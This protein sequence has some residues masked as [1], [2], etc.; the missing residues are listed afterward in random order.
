MTLAA[1][2]VQI[3]NVAF[4][5]AERGA[6]GLRELFLPLDHL[7]VRGGDPRLML[8]LGSGRNNYG[9]SPRPS[10]EC[11]SFAS[12]TASAISERAY[13]RAEAAC[14][15]LM[16]SAIRV[17]LT[18]AFDTR[19]EQMRE[20]L[21]AHLGLCS[22][23]VDVAFS[24]S[25]TDA[26]LHALFVARSLLGGALTT[27]IVSADQT[28]SGTAFTARGRHFAGTTASARQ[29][30]KNAPITGLSCDSVALPLLD[31]AT[32]AVKA[33][34]NADQVV[35]DAVD[36]VVAEGGVVLL[37]ILDSSQFGWR[38]PSDACLEEIATRWPDRVQVVVDACQ[39]RL[40]RA[41]L[42]TYLGRGYIVL[43]SGSKY[44]GGPAFSGALLL[45]AAA[46]RALKQNREVAPGL[47]DYTSRSDWPRGFVAL[48]NHLESRVNLGQ[49]LRWEAALEEI[50]TYYRIPD[51]FRA[52]ALKELG[53][54]IE[55][56]IML[57][58]SLRPV[59]SGTGGS[60]ADDEEFV[61]ATIFP[62]TVNGPR[63]PL[64]EAECRS[65]CQDLARDIGEV[66][67]HSDADR[68]IAARHCL[69]GE[70]AR[71]ERNVEHPAAVLR[72]CVG[73]RQV[74]EAWSPDATMARQSLERQ[75]DRI[76]VVVAKIELSLAHMRFA[77]ASHGG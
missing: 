64:S 57:S 25:G 42:K 13:R 41:R 44:F 67:R 35:L 24:P 77:E 51:A 18:E 1:P 16:G 73:A 11:F 72:L 4:R 50:G 26:Q 28:G 52:R 2:G 47:L 3:A 38:A 34:A 32:D 63:G 7:L 59:Q 45:P 27:I 17:G 66:T 8:D 40:G 37:Q 68:E 71:I 39:M 48:R 70:P 61:Q 53:E 54:T 22:R 46:S 9:C 49:W 58:P 12:S 36:R 31:P 76:A 75:I 69:I 15:G 5:D 65:L 20:E 23:D 21:R 56:L 6:D 10:P 55:T 62:F 14:E 60:A 74:I 29:I 30:E 33:H 19:L 43:I